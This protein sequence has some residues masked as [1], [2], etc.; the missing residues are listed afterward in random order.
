MSEIKL[1][2]TATVAHLY[3][4]VASNINLYRSGS[5][6]GMLA[7]SSQFLEPGCSIDQ[8]HLE[9]IKCTPTDDNE[10]DCC[11]AIFDGLQGM[12]A[13]LARDERLWTRLSHIELLNYSRVRWPIPADD[14]RAVA[15]IRKHFFAKGTRGV[16]RDNS[17]S[18]L[19]WMAKICEKV[20]GLS[21]KDSL[22]AFLFQSDVRAN[23]VERPTTSQNPELL[24]AVVNELHKSYGA[25]KA[26]YERERFR[27]VMKQL[28][29]I[30]GVVLL[31]VLDGDSLRAVVSE[32]SK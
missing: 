2:R 24:S 1:F 7:D 28:N 8:G 27:S 23:I 22:T 10:V 17:I 9:N 31:E 29:L 18:R 14:T 32:A 25:D 15:H 19:W 26:L 5:F 11:L 4:S 3:E 16:E 12:T 30:G 6:D 13:H 20:Q 21:L